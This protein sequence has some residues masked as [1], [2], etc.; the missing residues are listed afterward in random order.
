MEPAR[1]GKGSPDP[2]FARQNTIEIILCHKL[3]RPARRPA[4][5]SFFAIQASPSLPLTCAA[6]PVEARK[7]PSVSAPIHADS[8]ATEKVPEPP[9]SLFKECHLRGIGSPVTATLPTPTRLFAF[10]LSPYR[11]SQIRTIEPFD[12]IPEQH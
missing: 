11:S 4:P 8:I 12:D 9:A 6:R 1:F 5:T 10:K 3:S 7:P 2:D